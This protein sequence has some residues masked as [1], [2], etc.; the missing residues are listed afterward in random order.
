V[1]LR[2]CAC[3]GRQ[4]A[5]RDLEANGWTILRFN[6]YQLR[7]EAE[8]FCVPTIL[9]E[10]KRLNENPD[11]RWKA[12]KGLGLMSEGTQPDAQN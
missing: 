2:P 9:D 7:Q 10:L 6:S 1:A 11:P 3:R 8:R 12:V 5:G 4:F